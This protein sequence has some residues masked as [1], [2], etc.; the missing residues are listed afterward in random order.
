MYNMKNLTANQ[1]HNIMILVDL[2]DS[3]SVFCDLLH[4]FN[5]DLYF[6][7]SIEYKIYRQ[8]SEFLNIFNKLY[9]MQFV[10]I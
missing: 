1:I 7:L 4:F 8:I 3:F 2:L 9:F 6:S 5:V 10:S